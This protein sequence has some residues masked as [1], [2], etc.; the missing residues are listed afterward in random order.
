MI[1]RQEYLNRLEKAVARS[2]VTALTGPRQAGKTTLARQFS[3]DYISTVFDLESNSDMK[4]LENPELVLGS[5]NGLAVIDEI[6]RMP[7]LFSA[8]RV[9]AD[10]EQSKTRFL[11]LGSASP[12]MIK[13]VSESLAGR[14]EFVDITGFDL[15]ESGFNNLNSL[16][17]RGGFPR[18]FLAASNDASIAWRKNFIR[19]FLE[20][21]I[22]QLGIR[23]PASALE[24]FWYMLAHWHGQVWNASELGR[25]LGVGDKTM[26]N[27]LDILTGVFLIRQLQPWYA[28]IAKRQV[29]SPKI[30]FRDSGLLHALLDIQDDQNLYRHPKVGASWEGFII[31]Q[32]L[33]CLNY[34]PAWFWSTHSGGEIDL[35]IHHNGYRFGFEIKYSESPKV[36]AVL[37]KSA[38]LLELDHLF[39]VYPGTRCYPISEHITVFPAADI[40]ALPKHLTGMN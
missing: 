25:S 10:R 29:K 16:W 19:T 8:L 18:S 21:D 2:P 28:N 9:L 30:Y 22:P 39:V 24:R 37:R 40:V 27:Y 34:P 26:R 23:I 3:K 17:C 12:S 33:S 7:E 35:L 6:Q 11:I 32:I 15:Q 20:R 4:A 38:A 1:L 31:E 13:G 14:I 5:I 36:S